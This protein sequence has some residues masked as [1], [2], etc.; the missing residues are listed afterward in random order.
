[1]TT[2]D[3]KAEMEQLDALLEQER[4]ALLAGDLQ[5]IATLYDQKERLIE[6]LN[7]SEHRDLAHLMRLDG[8]VRRNQLLLNGALEGIRSVTQRMAALQQVRQ[9]LETYDRDGQKKR[10]DIRTD[11]SVEKRA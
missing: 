10:I 9:S 4:K 7:M 3:E 6:A 5:E 11:H 2:S 1:M 8:K